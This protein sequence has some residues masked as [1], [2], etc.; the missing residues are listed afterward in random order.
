ME[1]R[2]RRLILTEEAE[3]AGKWF[4]SLKDQSLLG[5]ELW[6]ERSEDPCEVYF[7]DYKAVDGR[8]L[9]HRF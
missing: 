8:R 4:F 3:I 7:Y 5:L 9:P 6:I 1:R 2:L